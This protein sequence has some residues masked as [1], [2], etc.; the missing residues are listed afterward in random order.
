LKI[1]APSN[2]ASNG[3]LIY[4][5]EFDAS[6]HIPTPGTTPLSELLA[7]FDDDAEFQAAMSEAR[8]SKGK[9]LYHDEPYSLT[10]LRLSAGLSQRQLA[11]KMDTSQSYIARLEAGA[12]DPGT[13]IISRLAVALGVEDSA[14]FRAVRHQLSTRGASD[15]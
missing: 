10:A 11:D 9:T 1:G 3:A 2:P 8:K 14:A 15:A 5:R 13:D 12:V 7:S 6:R 4:Y